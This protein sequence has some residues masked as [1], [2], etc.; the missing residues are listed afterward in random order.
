MYLERLNLK[1]QSSDSRL[2]IYLHCR[3]LDEISEPLLANLI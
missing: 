3:L 1:L 2:V